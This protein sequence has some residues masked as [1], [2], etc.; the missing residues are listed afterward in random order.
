MYM[1]MQLV[2]SR[3]RTAVPERVQICVMNVPRDMNLMKRKMPAKVGVCV[4][5]CVRVYMCEGV[6][7]VCVRM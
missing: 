7:V 5:V 2:I 6:C 4:C 1:Y 3:A